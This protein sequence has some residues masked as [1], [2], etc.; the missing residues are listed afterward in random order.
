MSGQ[1]YGSNSSKISSS[2]Y[3]KLD[4]DNY[5]IQRLLQSKGFY[6]RRD[7][8]NYDKFNRFGFLDV[9]DNIGTTREYIFIT[10]P[11]LHLFNNKNSSL[12][13]EEIADIPFFKDVMIRYPDVLKQLQKSYN[14]NPSPFINLITNSL[15]SSMDLPGISSDSIDTASTYQGFNIKYRGDSFESD[16]NHS[17]SLEFKDSKYLELYHLFKI[18][19][20]YQ[21]IKKDGDITPPSTTYLYNR[22]LHDQCAAYKFIVDEDGETILFYAKA[23]GVFPKSVPREVFG[24]LSDGGPL[25]FSIDFNASLVR[26]MDPLILSDFNNLTS[27]FHTGKST[28]GIWN[29]DYDMIDGRWCNIPYINTYEVVN[30][31]K[32]DISPIPRYKLK[33]R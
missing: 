15:N 32:P 17:F 22:E 13:N 9:Y 20:M 10:K 16:M 5:S 29:S 28:V 18:Y 25:T 2:V 1:V 4:I 11:D 27:K 23:W 30:K 8:R 31:V 7:I 33:W 24:N 6:E 21:R 3:K 26:D 12:L 19:D 14:G